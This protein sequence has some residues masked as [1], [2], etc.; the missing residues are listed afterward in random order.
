[1]L[2]AQLRGWREGGGGG[3]GGGGGEGCVRDDTTH[4]ECEVEGFLVM[5]Q[6]DEGEL[7]GEREDGSE[8]RVLGFR[9]GAGIHVADSA[10]IRSIH[11]SGWV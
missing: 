6:L 2:S 4:S 7:Q 10:A 9:K 1:M 11:V 3:G 5:G 8:E